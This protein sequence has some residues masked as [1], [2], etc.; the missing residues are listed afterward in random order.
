MK[1]KIRV[2][3]VSATQATTAS[4]SILMAIAGPMIIAAGVQ[5][6]IILHIALDLAARVFQH[7]GRDRWPG[8]RRKREAMPPLANNDQDQ[9]EADGKGNGRKGIS[10]PIE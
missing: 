9:T 8:S 6:S 7:F 3:A 2:A 5:P 1:T 4:V 10:E